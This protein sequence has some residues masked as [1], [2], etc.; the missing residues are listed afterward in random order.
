MFLIIGIFW[1]TKLLNKHFWKKFCNVIGSSRCHRRWAQYI[2]QEAFRERR[3]L[4]V[5]DL[6]PSRSRKLMSLDVAYRIVPWC[7]VSEWNSFQAITLI[8][9]LETF[10][11]HLW[12]STYVKVT[13]TLI[14]ICALCCCILVLSIKCVGSI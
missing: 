2:K 6:W 7:D 5:C 1:C 4:H 12:P 9:F 11:L 14:I 8:S 10:H 13:F 3:H